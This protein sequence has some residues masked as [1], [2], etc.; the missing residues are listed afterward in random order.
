MAVNEAS[1]L[2]HSFRALRHRN[3]RLFIGGQI[4]SLS[5]SWMQQVALGWLVY[6]LTH[7]PFM[8]GLVGFAGQFPAVFMAP[9]AGVWADRWSRHRMV[10]VTQTLG[11]LQALVLAALVLSERCAGG[12]PPRQHR[13]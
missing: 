1:Q 11:M 12:Q 3:F 7:S 6:R 4:V 5:G 9:V 2:R 8:L 13:R 10:I